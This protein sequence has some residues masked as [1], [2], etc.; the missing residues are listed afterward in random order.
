VETCMIPGIHQG[1]Q[2][3]FT[4]RIPIKRRVRALHAR[5]IFIAVRILSEINNRIRP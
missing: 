4:S 3:M 1:S 2:S 5:A